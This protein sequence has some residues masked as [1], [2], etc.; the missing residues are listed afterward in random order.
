M[1]A[2][3]DPRIA[4]IVLLAGTGVSGRE[5]MGPQLAA[6]Q[7]A[8]GRPAD[9]IERQLEAQARLMD[10]AIAGAPREEIAAAAAD[11]VDVQLENVPS[12]QRSGPARERS[13]SAS[14]R[15]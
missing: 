10:A 7:R 15:S 13:R 11:L 8:I 2:A 5:V 9:N 4:W 1:V 12:A 6:G 14:V 3:E